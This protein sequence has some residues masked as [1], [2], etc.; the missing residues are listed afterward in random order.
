MV[1]VSSTI[2]HSK[3]EGVKVLTLILIK[4]D[5][6]TRFTII[7]PLQE[8]GGI[9]EKGGEIFCGWVSAATS[10][11]RESRRHSANSELHRPAPSRG[12]LLIDAGCGWEAI[13]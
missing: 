12:M 13:S 7:E 2:E 5:G 8:N 6:H 10:I 9:V 3:T 1:K 11:H 4:N